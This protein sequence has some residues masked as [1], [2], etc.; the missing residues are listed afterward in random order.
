MCRDGGDKTMDCICNNTSQEG[1]E[2]AEPIKLI[3]KQVPPR[4]RPVGT[5]KHPAHE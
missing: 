4:R 5:L 3:I 2:E 1:M